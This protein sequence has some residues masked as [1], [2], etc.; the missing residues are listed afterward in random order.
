MVKKTL[1]KRDIERLESA[2]MSSILPDGEGGSGW[3]C[4]FTLV[5]CKR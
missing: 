1:R 4:L 2:S 3:A 5:N